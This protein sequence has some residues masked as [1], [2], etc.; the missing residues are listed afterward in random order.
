MSMIK[1]DT[2]KSQRITYSVLGLVE[3]EQKWDSFR[4]PRA[5]LFCWSIRNRWNYQNHHKYQKTL[6]ISTKNSLQCHGELTARLA[7]VAAQKWTI[8]WANSP[9]PVA[10]ANSSSV[11]CLTHSLFPFPIRA[12]HFIPFQSA[13]FRLDGMFTTLKMFFLWFGF[14]HT[15][16]VGLGRVHR[17]LYMTM[18]TNT[19]CNFLFDQSWKND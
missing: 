14:S 11:A 19:K 2:H 1:L 6:Q 16:V 9:I 10:Q 5:H 8:I 18:V 12:C 15:I 13:F 7:S 17:Y 4:D 3:P